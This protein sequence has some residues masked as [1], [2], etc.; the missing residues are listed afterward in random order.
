MSDNELLLALSEMIDNKLKPLNEKIG[1][2]EAD[3]NHGFDKVSKIETDMNHGFDKVS[4]I[5]ADMNHGFDKVSKIEADLNH[6][7]DKVSKIEADMNHGFDKVSKIEAD[8]NHGF[9]KVSK[10]EADMN[11]GFN[12]VSVI[13]ENEIRPDIKLLAENYLPAA[14]RYEKALMETENMK[15]DIELLK[16]IVMEHSDK[17][18]KIL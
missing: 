7:F 10:I 12:K 1:K 15:V 17:L 16:K 3:M 11:H 4:K 9:I 8:M 14:K 13:L 18:Q 2:I 6:G 5:E